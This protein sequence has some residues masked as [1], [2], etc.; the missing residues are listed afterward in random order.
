MP[1]NCFSN[2]A[3]TP[4]DY[5]Q[6]TFGHW[7]IAAY[8]AFVLLRDEDSH[9]FDLQQEHFWCRWSGLLIS[10][11]FD[12]GKELNRDLL[13]LIAK[14]HPNALV[15]G[16]YEVLVP[17]LTDCNFLERLGTAWI[18]QVEQTLVSILNA[19]ILKQSCNETILNILLQH[20]SKPAEAIAE[21][22]LA[23]TNDPQQRIIAA[24]RLGRS[25]SDGGQ[26]LV[27][28]LIQS[29]DALGKEIVERVSGFG[30]NGEF[31]KKW[32]ESALGSFFV[33]LTKRYPYE[34]IEAGGGAFSVTTSDPV[35]R[36][37]MR[38]LRR[39]VTAGPSKPLM[40]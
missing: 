19:A 18:P 5:W 30:E 16:L 7:V 20:G 3:P 27:W 4:N 11:R 17:Q 23:Q 14:T 15:N 36:Y 26:R 1:R 2:F 37:V 39:C 8:L 32:S 31:V 25:S 38:H 12:Y 29:S 21:S 9:F 24:I 10:Y 33:W 6:Q 22:M 28:P 40:P 34:E 13:E 35:V